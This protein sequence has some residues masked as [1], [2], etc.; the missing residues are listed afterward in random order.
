MADDVVIVEEVPCL[1]GINLTKL[2]FS[3]IEARNK[4]A[5]LR[6]SFC[7]ILSSLAVTFL[8]VFISYVDELGHRSWP[9]LLK[10]LQVFLF[11]TVIV[12]KVAGFRA[13][14]DAVKH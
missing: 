8:S 2:I 13:F 11:T 1:S 5:I 3:K 14:V 6:T 10:H 4:I 9:E 12:N 7:H